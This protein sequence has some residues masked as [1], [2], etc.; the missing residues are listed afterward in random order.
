MGQC[1][2]GLARHAFVGT[3]R[4]V[5]IAVAGHYRVP[6]H[7]TRIDT[8]GWVAGETF[9][10]ERERKR[11]A[12][13]QKK[14]TYDFRRIR[15]ILLIQPPVTRPSC[16]MPPVSPSTH[17]FLLLIIWSRSTEM[18]PLTTTPAEHTGRLDL[19][20]D[21][22]RSLWVDRVR[23]PASARSDDRERELERDAYACHR[24]A[25]DTRSIATAYRKRR[26]KTSMSESET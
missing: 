22:V 12:R 19:D 16:S 25:S 3:L 11:E 13:P 4:Y 10:G 20:R 8:V 6:E 14:K 26:E 18:S 23:R 21:R 2:G 15:V 17:L 1:S 24:G 7:E 9:Q 5:R